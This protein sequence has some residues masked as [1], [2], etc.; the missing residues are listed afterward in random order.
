VAGLPSETAQATLPW[1]WYSEP[2]LL[3]REQEQI[4]KRAWQYAGPAEHVASPGDYFTCRVGDVPVIVVRDRAGKLHAF[5]NV[6]RHRGSIL[7]EGSGN[8]ETLQCRYHAWTYGLD[9]RLR[10][11]PRARQEPGFETDGICLYELAIETWGPLLFVS[12]DPEAGP[13]AETLGGLPD[14]VA[15]GGVDVKRLRFQR[16]SE[17]EL[18]CNWKI[19]IEN[20]LEC[21][22]CPVAHPGFSAVVDV[23]PDAYRLET[24][25]RSSSQFGPLR[26]GRGAGEVP[27]GQFHWIWPVTKLYAMPGAQ[28]LAVGPVSPLGPERTSAYLDYYFAEDATDEEIAELIAFDDQVGLEDRALVESVQAGVRSGLLDEGRLMPE[29]ERLLAHFQG[30]VREALA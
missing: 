13:L 6:C 26:P 1:S 15:G 10:A 11:A 20:Y 9:G 30:L 17:S 29:S 8:R 12:P 14:L 22:H 4:F 5:L 16:R 18:A 2:E 23:S 27:E 25:E 3:R 7:V 21:Y 24:H 19:A 28:N